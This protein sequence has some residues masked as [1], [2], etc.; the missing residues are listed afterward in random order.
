MKLLEIYKRI[1]KQPLRLTRTKE[2]IVFIGNREYR[3][4]KIRYENGTFVCFEADKNEQWFDASIKPLEGKWVIVKDKDGKE[5]DNHQWMGHAWYDF[6]MGD[7]GD[8]DGWR[9][10][11][12]ICKWKYDYAK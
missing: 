9:S 12:D 5:W 10:Q 3:I 4:N 2:A 6:I 7:N 8:C 1:G 11:V